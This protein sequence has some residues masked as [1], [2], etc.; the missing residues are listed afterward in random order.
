MALYDEWGNK[1]GGPTRETFDELLDSMPDQKWA[2]QIAR[3][4]DFVRHEGENDDET[5]RTD[6]QEHG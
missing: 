2:D 4:F 1:I 5:E 6:T 3:N